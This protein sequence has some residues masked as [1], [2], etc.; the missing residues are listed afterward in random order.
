[1]RHS[2]DRKVVFP[3][4]KRHRLEGD[5]HVVTIRPAPKFDP[6]TASTAQLLTNGFP[7]VP[8]EP[9]HR[10]RFERM[11]NR[12]KNKFHYVEPTFR[13]D[14]TKTYGPRQRRPTEGT[15]TST[16][17][18]GAVVN[19]PAGQTFKW[20]EGDW[21][22]PP[23]SAPTQDQTYY[24]ATWIGIDGDGSPDVFQAGVESTVQADG[25][26][27]SIEYYPWWEWYPDPM[28]Q[29][30][31][32]PVSPG[33]KITMILCSS[34]GA[35]ST[36]GTVY[37]TNT[38]TG[39]ATSVT[40]TA[41]SGTQLVGNCA[42]WIVE[43]PTVGGS[44][45]A[46]GDYGSVT[47]TV[48]EAV[49]ETNT[50]VDGGTGDTIN[51]TAGGTV[52]SEAT[53]ITTTSVECEYVGPTGGPIVVTRKVAPHFEFPAFPPPE[54]APAASVPA[55]AATT[56]KIADLI[57]SLTG[58][59]NPVALVGVVGLVA[60]TGIVAATGLVALAAISKDKQ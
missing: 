21:T 60:V 16:N 41:P 58:G 59:S 42:E 37:W 15:E 33:D 24:C 52:V 4:M 30:T 53:V 20:I 35:G 54:P 34:G 46:L 50:T 26:A 39:A 32:F 9:H 19:P 51:M 57:G 31:N 18:S 13:V 23:V 8:D 28:V 40:L 56:P 44:Q 7:A 43:A 11:W 47:F 17:W 48:C 27:I 38:T 14:R 5:I 25:T 22:V 45:S 2:S 6:L 49:T 36:T 55:P 12:I 3:M 1:M 29:I 10:Q